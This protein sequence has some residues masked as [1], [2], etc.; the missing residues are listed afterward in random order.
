MEEAEALSTSLITTNLASVIGEFTLYFWLRVNNKIVNPTFLYYYFSTKSM[1]KF[2]NNIAIGAAV[3]GIN[4]GLLKNLPVILPTKIEQ[5][6][7]AK[8]LDYFFD[9]IENNNQRITPSSSKQ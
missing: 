1:V 9:L 8:S 7:I 3:P 6:L 2:I 5:D 4:L